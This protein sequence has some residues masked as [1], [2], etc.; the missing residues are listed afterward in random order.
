MNILLFDNRFSEIAT[1][2]S[3]A[4]RIHYVCSIINNPI[5]GSITRYFRRYERSQI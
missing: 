1:Y 4:G 5:S 2:T 3:S